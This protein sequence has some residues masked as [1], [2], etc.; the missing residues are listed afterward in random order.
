M[1][2]SPAANMAALAHRPACRIEALSVSADHIGRMLIS[3]RTPG[4]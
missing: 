3:W 2:V 1:E 4:G